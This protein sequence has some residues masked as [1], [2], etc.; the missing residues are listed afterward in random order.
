MNGLPRILFN[1]ILMVTNGVNQTLPNP[2][3]LEESKRHKSTNIKANHHKYSSNR[4]SS[5]NCNNPADGD[6]HNKQMLKIANLNP[7]N[8]GVC[9]GLRNSN[10][11]IPQIPANN[12]NLPH[13]QAEKR[14][15]HLVRLR[16]IKL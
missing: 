1:K 4:R 5:K 8:P 9:R 14:K 15:H 3:S 16:P 11:S 7:N 13:Y 10:L 6:Y 2:Q 12:N